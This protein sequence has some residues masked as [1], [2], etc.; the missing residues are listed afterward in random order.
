MQITEE[1]IRRLVIEVVDRIESLRQNSL[2]ATGPKSEAE[3]FS[4]K[5]M[6]GTDIEMYHRRRIVVIKVNPRTILTPLARERAR[7]LGVSL[8]PA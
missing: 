2:A 8:I 1:L 6:T 5:V 3:E 4:G 7:D